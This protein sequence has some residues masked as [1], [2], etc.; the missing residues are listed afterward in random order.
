[1]FVL[2]WSYSQSAVYLHKTKHISVTG[3]TGPTGI[4]TFY[5]QGLEGL[6]GTYTREK[7]V[8]FKKLENKGG[9]VSMVKKWISMNA[10]NFIEELWLNSNH[11]P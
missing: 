1:M 11:F 8:F 9:G 3:L 4:K 7:K 5:G 10:P 2:R 6:Y